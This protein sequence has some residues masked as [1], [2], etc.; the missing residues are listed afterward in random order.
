MAYPVF[1]RARRWIS[2]PRLLTASVAAILPLRLAFAAET[3]ARKPNIVV[4]LTDD[5][6]YADISC[7]PHHPPEVST[8][9]MDALCAAGVRFTNGY[10]SG[11]VCSP[12]RSGLMTGRYQQ[13]FGIYTAGEG[14]SG[15]PLTE[16]FFPQYLKP[17]GYVS[18]AFGKWH[19]G[20]T[21]EYNAINRGFDEFYGFMGRGAHDYFKLDN[22]DSPIYR[23]LDPFADNGYLTHRITDEA[24]SF[25]TR[26]KDQ[27]FFA[28]VAYNA[29]HSPPE[30]PEEDI[31]KYHVDD[32]SRNVLMAML[33]HLDNGI[34]KIIETL[35]KEGL[36]E[37]TLIFFLTDNGGSKGMHACNAP[38]KGFKGSNYEGGV[39]VP[40]AV[41]WPEHLTAGTTSGV[42]VMSFDILPTALAA[43]GISLPT[44][45]IIDGKNILPAA[46]GKPDPIHDFLC[47]NSGSGEWSIRKGD[48]KLHG[49][50][51]QSELINLKTDPAETTN[52]SAERPEV[53]EELKDIYEKWL[54]EMAEPVKGGVK[55][56]TPENAA[57]AAKAG[58]PEKDEGPAPEGAQP[59]KAAKAKGPTS[60][61]AGKETVESMSPERRAI[62]EQRRAERKAAKKS[63]DG[64]AE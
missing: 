64:K 32:P 55:V 20:L 2:L 58:A 19:Q 35:K 5:Q 51:D 18:G 39:R 62:W 63:A 50:K 8:P 24:I 57:K 21:L 61:A 36:Y 52:A 11:N 16:V 49:T 40:F 1:N 60:K 28:Y 33:L 14:G 4:I 25:I 45:R 9:H 3:A 6:G 47:W 31:D 38:L 44:D 43:A 41:V 27:P 15:V 54:S 26:H 56:W 10:T 53:V 22:P 7:N 23:N 17:A 37:N 30:A 48:W 13:R 59:G 12:T 42:P 34:G 46:E 29:V